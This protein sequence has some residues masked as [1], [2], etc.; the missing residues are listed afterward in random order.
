VLETAIRKVE[1]WQSRALA[2]QSASYAL[3]VR[4]K[5]ARPW[6]VSNRSYGRKMFFRQTVIGSLQNQIRLMELRDMELAG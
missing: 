3:R 1:D 6:A 5:C 2:C 4:S